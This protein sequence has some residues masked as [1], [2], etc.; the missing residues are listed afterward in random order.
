MTLNLK[1]YDI[2]ERIRIFTRNYSNETEVLVCE[3]HHLEK[4]VGD[5]LGG[6]FKMT[7]VDKGTVIIFHNCLGDYIEYHRGKKHGYLHEG[8][9]SS[10]T[11]C[12]RNF[13]TIV[14]K[15]DLITTYVERVCVSINS[16][17]EKIIHRF[18]YVRA[19]KEIGVPG[20]LH[21]VAKRILNVA[22]SELKIERR[23]VPYTPM[24]IALNCPRLRLSLNIMR[25]DHEGIEIMKKLH[26]HFGSEIST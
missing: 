13:D 26:T 16:T 21:Y 8:K 11:A 2:E 23:L 7:L 18:R 5:Y 17:S 9:V 20:L 14:E 12:T 22:L 4:V 25:S 3:Q 15:Y 10:I 24:S 19:F 1:L 6:N